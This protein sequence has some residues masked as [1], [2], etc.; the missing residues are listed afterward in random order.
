MQQKNIKQGTTFAIPREPLSGIWR[1]VTATAD[2]RQ[3]P[4]G[5]RNRLGFTLIELLVVVLI[6]GILAAVALPQYQVAV[7]KA[8]IMRLLPLMHSIKEAQQTYYLASGQYT[9]KFSELDIDVPAGGTVIGDY[10]VAYANF[11]CALL[12]SSAS[13]KCGQGVDSSE[14]KL[15][16]ELYYGPSITFCWA[17]NTTEKDICKSICKKAL[18]DNGN[19][20]FSCWF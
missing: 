8:K 19:G 17:Y 11:K 5:E 1:F 18:T 16:L 6:I 2:P 4:S 10:Y 20:V 15:H 14:R 3:K 13:I 12:G 9:N 7:G